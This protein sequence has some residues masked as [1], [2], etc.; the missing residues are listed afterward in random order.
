MPALTFQEKA[1]RKTRWTGLKA[2]VIALGLVAA[3]A[4][5]AQASPLLA[6]A[7]S[8]TI[9]NGTGVTGTPGLSIDSV[10]GG[11]FMSPSSLNLGAFHAEALASGQSTTYS[12]TP[13]HFTFKALTV[14]GA[15][16]QVNQTPI[17]VSGVLNGTLSGPSQSSVT[18]TFDKASP[19]SYQ[20]LTGLY[21]NTLTIPDSPLS[22]VPSTTNSGVT[23]AQAILSNIAITSPV[24]EPSTI[25]LF[26]STVI[27]LG[28]RRQIRRSR[29]IG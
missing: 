4:G 27:G 15:A 28:L 11:S 12:N 16:P 26:A 25:L 1:M 23:T 14:D 24:P 5:G 8:G 18:A 6:Y 13:F 17:D 19:G 2:S 7:S 10:M 29:P 21:S 9:D 22:I 20:F 3:V